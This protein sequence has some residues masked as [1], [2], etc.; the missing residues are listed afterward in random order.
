[1]RSALCYVHCPVPAFWIG[2]LALN[3]CNDARRFE[4]L[5]RIRHFEFLDNAQRFMGGLDRLVDLFISVSG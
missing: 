5:S 4:W 3:M 1:M 2:L